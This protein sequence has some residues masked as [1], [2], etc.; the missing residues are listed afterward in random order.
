MPFE[1]NFKKSAVKDLLKLSKS[2]SKE[3]MLK[4]LENLSKD[5]ESFPILKGRHKGLRKFRIGNYRVIFT[6][7][8][9]EVLILYVGHRKDIYSSLN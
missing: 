5:P 1:I 8:E 3:I 2:E 6:I 4:I 7:I 9:R